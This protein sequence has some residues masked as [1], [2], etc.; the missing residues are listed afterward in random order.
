MAD[1]TLMEITRR[2]STEDAARFDRM[3]ARGLK[4]PR[5]PDE[6]PARRKPK[7]AR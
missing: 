2:Y 3:L 4:V 7:R 1:L 6:K 5:A